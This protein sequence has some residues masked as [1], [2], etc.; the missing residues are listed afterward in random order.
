MKT[1]PDAI[2]IG[3]IHLRDDQPRCRLDDFLATQKRKGQWL[4]ELWNKFSNPPILQPGDVFDRWKA[5][6]QT[7]NL[8]MLYFP[9]MVTIVGNPGKHNYQTQEGFEKDALSVVDSSGRG[10]EVTKEGVTF[11]KFNVHP[12]LWGEEPKKVSVEDKAY[13]RNILLTHRNLLDGPSAYDGEDSQKFL[14]KCSAMGYDLVLSGHNHKPFV[15]QHGRSLL[16]NPGSFTRQSASED[17]R[18][19][20]YLWYARTNTVEAVYI[21]IEEGVISRDH[22]D[23]PKVRD[24]RIEAFVKRLDQ[25]LEISINFKDNVLARLS[26]TKIRDIVTERIME[27]VDES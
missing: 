4:R 15:K 3:D 6:P 12:C 1:L 5:S 9:P 2:L 21:P 7:I 19:K 8:A 26:K 25:D 20:V 13:R 11:K 22:I 17:H 10:W 23:E 18:P 16:I 24:E 27:A 14:E